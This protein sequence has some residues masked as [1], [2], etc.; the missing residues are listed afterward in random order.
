MV[1]ILET[2][3]KKTE[4]QRC[5][6]KMDQQDRRH[7]FSG[8]LEVDEKN[9]GSSPSLYVRSLLISVTFPK[10]AANSGSI[11]AFD[12]TQIWAY[13]KIQGFQFFLLAKKNVHFTKAA[14]G[15]G[16]RVTSIF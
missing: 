10:W 4:L 9:I 15:F 13:P 12:L 3:S 1:S 2:P 5:L 14:G 11:N 7:A 16:K 8:W 6:L